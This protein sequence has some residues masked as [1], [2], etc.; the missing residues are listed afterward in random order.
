[1]RD[2]I[3]VIHTASSVDALGI[4]DDAICAK[5][6]KENAVKCKNMKAASIALTTMND[7]QSEMVESAAGT[8]SASGAG[9]ESSDCT[10]LSDGDEGA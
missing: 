10:V 6:L 3:P 8:E 2:K 1:M 5:I 9:P 4:E 7:D